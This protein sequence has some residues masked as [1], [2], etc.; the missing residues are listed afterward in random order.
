MIVQCDKCKTKFRIGDDKLTDSGI[1]VRCSRC[2]HVFVVQREDHS[3]I[4]FNE[5]GPETAR[6]SPMTMASLAA[7]STRAPSLPPFS[8]EGA[9]TAP[10]VLPLP[11]PLPEERATIP[12]AGLGFAALP[13]EPSPS[14][15]PSPP[16]LPRPSSS[17]GAG[18]PSFPSFPPFP[19][20]DTLAS[21]PPRPRIP[22]AATNPLDRFPPPP[23][24]DTHDD[25]FEDERSPPTFA[26]PL[27]PR[28]VFDTPSPALDHPSFGGGEAAFPPSPFGPGGL[29]SGLESSA[30][31]K[32]VS[33]DI[34]GL[35]A[36]DDPFAG[37]DVQTVPPMDGEEPFEPVGPALSADGKVLGR[38][39]L[40]KAAMPNLAG[41]EH[42][43]TTAIAAAYD[44]RPVRKSKQRSATTGKPRW[45]TWVG[46]GLGLG[47]AAFVYPGVVSR[48]VDPLMGEAASLSEALPGVDVQG[49]RATVYVPQG[50]LG[51]TTPAPLLV[52]T[53]IAKNLGKPI[54]GQVRAV[55]LLLDDE[56][57]V[58]KRSAPLGVLLDE[59]DLSGAINLEA[60]DAAYARRGAQAPGSLPAGAERRFMVVFP[61]VPAGAE[62]RTIRVELVPETG[63]RAAR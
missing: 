56:A 10:N 28:A 34:P 29:L 20:Q 31:E 1:K 13:T 33:G 49:L 43:E 57:V 52:V 30:S 60:L 55:A 37:L 53:G 63:A 47:I 61:S 17:I 45:P 41:D 58:E 39:D 51:G 27:Q 42:H 14:Q 19:A 8:F 15:R 36:A 18:L 5:R 44:P 7:A 22:A 11:S 35:L 40:G 32:E 48:A 6:V 9:Q 38:I 23:P 4:F 12:V 54:D 25:G 24:L 26:A 46:I 21:A 2:A 3:G 59:R 16:P 62:L 50:E